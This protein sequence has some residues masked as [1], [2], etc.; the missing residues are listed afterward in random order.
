MTTIA[1]IQSRSIRPQQTKMIERFAITQARVIDQ[2]LAFNPAERSDYNWVSGDTLIVE[3]ASHLLAHQ[4]ASGL[5]E[6]IET[7]LGQGVTLWFAN[8][9]ESLIPDS[10]ADP[11]TILRVIADSVHVSSLTLK[12][13]LKA[14]DAAQRR[15]QAGFANGRIP[16]ERVR[17][18]LDQHQVMIQNTIGQGMT[19]SALA[20]QLGVSRSTLYVWLGKQDGRDK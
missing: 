15:K 5:L 12:R 13:Q 18:K 17:S 16:G 2:W 1:L 8:T 4:S 3:T 20:K 11:S 10:T 7:W 19:K 9:R 14:K 6:M